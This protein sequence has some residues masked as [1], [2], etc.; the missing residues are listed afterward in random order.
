MGA[1]PYIEDILFG[2]EIRGHYRFVPKEYQ[3]D[4]LS[5]GP[6]TS[7]NPEFPGQRPW[8][9]QAPYPV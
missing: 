2:F 8:S 3:L 4:N 9:A 7:D 6:A 1:G 5:F